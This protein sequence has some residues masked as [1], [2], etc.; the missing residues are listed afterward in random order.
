MP[1]WQVG[2]RG[3]RY[4]KSYQK[5]YSSTMNTLV[6]V[7]THRLASAAFAIHRSAADRCPKSLL[8]VRQNTM[9]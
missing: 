4:R 3:K 2:L 8:S 9:P 1:E 5:S 7:S 6:S